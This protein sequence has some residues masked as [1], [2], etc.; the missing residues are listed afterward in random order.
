MSSLPAGMYLAL[1]ALV[2]VAAGCLVGLERMAGEGK[3]AVV[4]AAATEMKRTLGRLD[5]NSL[6]AGGGDYAPGLQ[7]AGASSGSSATV[8]RHRQRHHDDREWAAAIRPATAAPAPGSAIGGVIERI[9]SYLPGLAH[10][11]SQS[12][13]P[14]KVDT[15]RCAEV[16]GDSSGKENRIV[17]CTLHLVHNP[18]C[19]FR[20]GYHSEN[21][22]IPPARADNRE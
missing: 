3:A 14:A 1:V 9:P 16:D 15:S 22:R 2:E 17:A 18:R 21:H 10:C 12:N 11:A 4:A 6:V 19:A 13:V 7:R 8:V 20:Y 5:M